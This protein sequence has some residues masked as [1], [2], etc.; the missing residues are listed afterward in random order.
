MVLLE[1]NQRNKLYLSW[2]PVSCN[3]YKRTSAKRR[4]VTVTRNSSHFKREIPYLHGEDNLQFSSSV[5]EEE[6]EMTAQKHENPKNDIAGDISG[7]KID[8]AMQ[9][10]ELRRYPRRQNRNIRPQ[11]YE[12]I[13]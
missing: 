6:G 13:R 10:V 2:D 3:R 5:E 11:Y 1:Q 7:E 9:D 8:N 12:E 4:G